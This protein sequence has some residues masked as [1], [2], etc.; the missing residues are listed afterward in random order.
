MGF[1]SQG[2]QDLSKQQFEQQ[3]REQESRY[4]QKL[5]EE[6]Q[7]RALENQVAGAPKPVS[8]LISSNGFVSPVPHGATGPHQTR[9]PG[10]MFS[11]G[12]GGHSFGSSSNPYSFDSRTAIVRVMD[13]SNNHPQRTVYTNKDHQPVNPFTGRHDMKKGHFNHD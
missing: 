5:R 1:Q 11:G 13:E 10:V 9:T 4:Q 7:R 3:K 2:A 8:A 6:Q 12:S